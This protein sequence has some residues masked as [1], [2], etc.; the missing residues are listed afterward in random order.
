MNRGCGQ[1]LAESA[2][3]TLS[4][5]RTT[6]GIGDKSITHAMRTANL[7]F[8]VPVLVA[9]FVNFFR[10]VTNVHRVVLST[11][12]LHDPDKMEK[13]GRRMNAR[14]KLHWQHGYAPGTSWH[15]VPLEPCATTSCDV[16]AVC[17][18]SHEFQF[19]L[20]VVPRAP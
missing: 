4:N 15:S 16:F 17:Q 13:G 3:H 20:T 14:H 11:Q 6:S 9:Q 12:W 5:R 10:D 18:T 19:F 7:P 2:H 1:M 8:A